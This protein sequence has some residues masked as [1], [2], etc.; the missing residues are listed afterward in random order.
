MR[1]CELGALLQNLKTYYFRTNHFVGILHFWHPA[2]QYLGSDY[3]MSTGLSRY[4]KKQEEGIILHQ[5]GD[6]TGYISPGESFFYKK[7]TLIRN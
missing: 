7:K 3:M 5:V 2:Q 1:I 6:T 4:I